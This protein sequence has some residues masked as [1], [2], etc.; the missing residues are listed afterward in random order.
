MR[1]LR[2]QGCDL[3]PN[4]ASL[5]ALQGNIEI[6]AFV[7]QNGSDLSDC[8]KAAATTGSLPCL[9]YA[10][11]HGCPWDEETVKAAIS[12]RSWKCLTYSLRHR[13][14][15]WQH[16]V[17]TLYLHWTATVLVNALKNQ[18][19]KQSALWCFE[20]LC[21]L[22]SAVVYILILY[23]R[24]VGK[25]L[26]VRSADRIAQSYFCV[27]LLFVTGEGILEVSWPLGLLK[28]VVF[29]L[30]TGALVVINVYYITFEFTFLV[31]QE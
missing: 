21:I 16:F 5:A 26:S 24:H 23:R 31:H 10:H 17:A 12:A 15:W 28:S 4:A 18:R 25:Y 2:A 13:A 7:H 19:K 20:I 6:L 3:P 30:L 1:F 22:T 11:E 29:L 9:R 8:C 14:G 27:L